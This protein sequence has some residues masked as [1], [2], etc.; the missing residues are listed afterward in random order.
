M[1]KQAGSA[2]TA[3]IYGAPLAAEQIRDSRYRAGAM[4]P[5]GAFRILSSGS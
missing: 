3:N 5:W 1:P 2:F 4:P